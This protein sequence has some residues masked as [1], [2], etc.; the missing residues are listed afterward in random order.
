MR[1][2]LVIQKNADTG[3]H[4]QNGLHA[5][6]LAAKEFRRQI[7]YVLMGQLAGSTVVGSVSETKLVEWMPN[8][9]QSTPNGL[10]AQ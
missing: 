4:G 8:V 9:P 5:L 7:V 6:S 2:G 10:D 3:M 1:L